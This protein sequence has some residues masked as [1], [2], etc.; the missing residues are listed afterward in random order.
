MGKIS[1]GNEQQKSAEMTEYEDITESN[2]FDVKSMLDSLSP[3]RAQKILEQIPNFATSMKDILEPYAERLDKIS[4]ANTESLNTYYE[5]ARDII[6][7][8]S[9]RDGCGNNGRCLYSE[10]SPGTATYT[11]GLTAGWSGIFHRK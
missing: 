8:L 2:I 6:E 9:C 7:A 4:Q 11:D 5:S 3:E 1:S 10:F